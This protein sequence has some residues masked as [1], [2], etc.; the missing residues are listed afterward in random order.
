MTK[1]LFYNI[2]ERIA[3]L[4]TATKI[5]AQQTASFMKQFNVVIARLDKLEKPVEKK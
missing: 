3:N 4:E 2:G 1:E 5:A